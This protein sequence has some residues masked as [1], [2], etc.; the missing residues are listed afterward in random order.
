MQLQQRINAF[1][2]LGAFF[3]QFGENP[4]QKKQA[5]PHND[6]FFSEM[7]HTLQ[8]AKAQN[9]WFTEDNLRFTCKSWGEALTESNLKQWLSAYEIPETAPGKKVAI[10]MAGNIPLVGFHD[11]LCV[12]LSGHSVLGKLSS[13]DKVLLPFVCKYLIAIEPGFKDKIELTTKKLEDFDAVIATGSDNTALYFEQYFGKYPHIIRKNRNSVALINGKET[14]QQME[15]LAGDIFRYFG[16]GCRNV[17]KIY[18]PEDYNWD[19]FFNGMFAWKDVINN[20]KYI[21]NYDYNKAVYLMSTIKLLDNE[22]LLLKEDTGFSSPISVVF[23]ETYTSVEKI[24]EQLASAEE[25]IQCIV[26]EN[27]IPFGEAQKPELWDY[28]DGVDT[29]QFLI[30]GF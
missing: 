29:I 6:S 12:L 11:F 27:H 16:L 14:P 21:N 26:S 24:S 28:A 8:L 23:Y 5:L 4:P 15:A 7:E 20:H 22:F 2:Q 19:H 9:T 17:S 30:S 25:K 3:S 18:V 1:V 10:V 13:N